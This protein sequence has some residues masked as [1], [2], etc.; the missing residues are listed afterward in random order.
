MQKGGIGREPIVR[1]KPNVPWPCRARG[2]DLVGRGAR[3]LR[4]SNGLAPFSVGGG[5]YVL[6]GRQR[7]GITCCGAIFSM[8][9]ELEVLPCD[10]A[11]FC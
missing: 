6:P 8:C 7:A 11:V 10:M 9:C 2:R 4:P 3:A 1:N 5:V